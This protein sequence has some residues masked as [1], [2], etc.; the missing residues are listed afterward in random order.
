M[1]KVVHVS[2][3]VRWELTNAI[4]VMSAVILNTVVEKRMAQK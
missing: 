3:D 4:K 1:G 2:Q